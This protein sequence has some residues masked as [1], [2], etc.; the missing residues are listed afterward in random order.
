M[1]N[2]HRIILSLF[3]LL[4]YITCYSQVSGII[5]YTNGTV[6]ELENIEEL[7][8]KLHYYSLKSSGSSLNE[9]GN[10]ERALPVER[11]QQINFIY[12]KAKGIHDFYYLLTVKG[13]MKNNI[14][15]KKIIRIW[16]WME[17]SSPQTNAI[18]NSRVVFFYNEKKVKIDRIIFNAAD[19]NSYTGIPGN[20]LLLP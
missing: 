18:S 8:L 10:Y 5:Y 14:P 11:L 19:L 2:I 1:I 3:I 12:E 20:G 7:Y 17:I 15:F 16:D 13:T 9:P 4:F 6:T